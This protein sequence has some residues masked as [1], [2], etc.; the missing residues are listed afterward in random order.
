M[1]FE[2]YGTEKLKKWR[3]NLLIAS[4]FMLV[5]MCFVLGVG[6]YQVANKE[7]SNLIYL[8]PAVFGPLTF[9]PLLVSTAVDK[10]LKKRSKK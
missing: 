4:I 6:L 7:D 1:A 9:L 3:R 2:K 10:E 5:L 8:V